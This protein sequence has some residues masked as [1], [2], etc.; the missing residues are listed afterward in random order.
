MAIATSNPT[1]L[2]ASEITSKLVGESSTIKIKP[3]TALA[4]VVMLPKPVQ[5][6]DA[7]E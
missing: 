3:V 7:V 1:S 4:D 5:W 6:E 2:S